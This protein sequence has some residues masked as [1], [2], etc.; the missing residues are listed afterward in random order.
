VRERRREWVDMIA[1]QLLKYYN[2]HV[3]FRTL[4]QRAPSRSHSKLVSGWRIQSSLTTG[5]DAVILVDSPAT[6]RS[7]EVAPK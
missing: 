6:A 5:F 2:F 3:E 4:T 7:A 1:G